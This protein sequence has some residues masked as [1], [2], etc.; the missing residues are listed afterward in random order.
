MINLAESSVVDLNGL[1]DFESFYKELKDN[2]SIE[3][4]KFT[5]KNA[6]EAFETGGVYQISMSDYDEVNGWVNDCIDSSEIKPKPK[7]VDHLFKRAMTDLTDVINEHKKNT[8][9]FE[10]IIDITYAATIGKGLYFE[11]FQ[12][13]NSDLFLSMTSRFTLEDSF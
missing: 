8:I 12:N 7:V 11:F 4:V 13:E 1:I 2:T 9:I 6:S 3:V 5:D 10:P